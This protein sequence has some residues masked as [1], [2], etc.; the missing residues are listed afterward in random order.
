[1]TPIFVE[2]PL[3]RLTIDEKV[4]PDSDTSCV[5]EHLTYYCSKFEPLPAVTISV[6]QGD[7]L[8]TRGHK[9]LQAARALGRP[10]MRAVIKAASS[11]RAVNEFL[12]RPG[13]RSLGPQAA[14][15][16]EATD[17]RPLSWH[18]IYFRHA[19]EAEEVWALERSLASSFEE[20]QSGAFKVTYDP[21][22]WRAEFQ[23]RTPVGDQ[24][25]AN[26]YLAVLL[27]FHH[28]CAPIATWQGRK[29]SS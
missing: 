28:R 5:L 12:S 8:V 20:S 29:F 22:Q 6:D 9:Y 17:A 25:W 23:A 14:S 18:V 7:G 2:V 13:V 24:D 10:S 26:A 1:M 15:S 16:F 11:E 27:D 21:G 19:L 3:E 4:S